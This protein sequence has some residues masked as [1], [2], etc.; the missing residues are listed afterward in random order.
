MVP[1]FARLTGVQRRI[2]VYPWGD[3]VEVS[4]LYD[5]NV[6]SNYKVGQKGPPIHFSWG[7]WS[8]VH[9]YT[10]N[11]TV[12]R[13]SGGYEISG[14]SPD[15]W[16]SP[17]R[18]ITFGF[19][20]YI[21]DPLT[22]LVNRMYNACGGLLDYDR[23][24]ALS[25]NTRNRLITECIVKV[26]DRKANYG[27]SIAEGRKTLGYIAQTSLR[28]FR[29]Y[30]ALRRGNFRSFVKALGAS[31]KRLR[32]G[33]TA[34]N[35]WLE[36]QYAWLPLLS[37]IYDTYNIMRDGIGRKSLTLKGTRQLEDEIAYR[38]HADYWWDL[39]GTCK[40]RHRCIL[41]FRLTNETADD[42]YS[43]G[44]INPVEVAWAILPYSFVIDWFLPVG[45]VLEAY[46]A[47]QGLTFVDG[48][49]TSKAEV[50]GGGPKIFPGYYKTDFSWNF[51]H[52]AIRREKVYTAIPAI[53]VKSPFS[54]THVVSALALL[55]NLRR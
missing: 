7:K 28:F 29:A 17:Y 33:M 47:L 42:F 38:D 8:P 10:R 30:K 44:L 15:V 27:E 31:P 5:W 9:E 51:E 13:L 21:S 45:N 40:V 50:S 16:S 52:F 25:Q 32:S 12:L 36:Y 53:Y 20:R 2:D 19:P 55:R 24:P 18:E 49:I 26:G 37:D 46:S 54:S 35:V 41:Y 22:A 34:S 39:N 43:L 6:V 1:E 4:F 48:C 11:G 23:Y 14:S 3:P